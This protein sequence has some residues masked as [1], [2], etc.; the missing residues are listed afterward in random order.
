MANS[1]MQHRRRGGSYGSSSSSVAIPSQEELLVN[2][3][4]IADRAFPAATAPTQMAPIAEIAE[5]RTE[6][7]QLKESIQRQEAM[8]AQLLRQQQPVIAPVPALVEPLYQAQFQP[9]R[10]QPNAQN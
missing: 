8:L 10:Y 6:V 7:T 3:I 4:A 1:P 2:L 9:N 5:L